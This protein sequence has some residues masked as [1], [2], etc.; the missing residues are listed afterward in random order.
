MQPNSYSSKTLLGNWY[1]HR[2]DPNVDSR[3]LIN[4]RVSCC[5]IQMPIPT[6]FNRWETTHKSHYVRPEK[7]SLH[8]NTGPRKFLNQD[9][10][11]RYLDKIDGDIANE[12]FG[13]TALDTKEKQ[14]TMNTTTHSAY[15]GPHSEYSYNKDFV[16]GQTGFFSAVPSADASPFAQQGLQLTSTRQKGASVQA[17]KKG[18]EMPPM[19]PLGN[20]SAAHGEIL[21]I[22]GF[23][24]KTNT[25]VQ[26]S[27]CHNT[28]TTVLQ[29]EERRDDSLDQ[30][31]K[32][33]TMRQTSAKAT[34]QKSMPASVPY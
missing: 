27:W 10:I 25:L 15:G 30:F 31:V 3:E 20:L 7:N 34:T 11:G 4:A 22:K 13:L 32:T 8:S 18:E 21:R 26:R 6:E 17:L 12:A 19:K 14:S 9:N 16:A 24:P 2:L 29:A 28:L 5:P 1:D 33:Q 23:D